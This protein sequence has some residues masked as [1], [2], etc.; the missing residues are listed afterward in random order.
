MRGRRRR[1]NTLLSGRRSLPIKIAIVAV[2]IIVLVLL[3]IPSNSGGGSGADIKN[4][5]K[6]G[7]LRVGVSNS[8]AGFSDG[9]NGLEIELARRI[10]SEIFPDIKT[11]PSRLTTVVIA[12]SFMSTHFSDSS[13]DIAIMQCPKGL[14]SSKYSYSDSY[15]TDSCI[16]AIKG[17]D[18]E[19][20]PISELSIGVLTNSICKVRITTYLSAEGLKSAVTE[21]PT[22]ETLLNGLKNGEVKACVLPGIYYKKFAAEHSLKAHSVKLPDIEYAVVCSPEN[23]D[24]IYLTNTLLADMKKSGELDKLINKYTGG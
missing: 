5:K 6:R 10:A 13:V 9:K 21:Y 18:D 4:V 20:K 24:F 23:E 15:Y 16:I 12:P 11:N 19:N 7:T 22:Y 8:M 3:L 1:K 2:I 14:Y 17:G